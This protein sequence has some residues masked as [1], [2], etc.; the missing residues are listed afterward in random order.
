MPAPAGIDRLDRPPPAEWYSYNF[1]QAERFSMAS[2]ED[3]PNAIM[4]VKQ[5]MASYFRVNPDG[6]SIPG[7]FLTG[8]SFTG[9]TREEIGFVAFT[10]RRRSQCFCIAS[11]SRS[12][13]RMDVCVWST[14]PG[15]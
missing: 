6:C 2:A 12:T 13:S 5:V 4:T 15:S 10:Y 1:S 11:T 8:F 9:S 14:N 3:Y 7:G